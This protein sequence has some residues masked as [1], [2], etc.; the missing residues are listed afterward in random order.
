VS[1]SLER[2]DD[3]WDDLARQVDWYRDEAGPAVALRFVDAV[4]AT[5]RALLEQPGVGRLRFRDWPELRGVRSFRVRRPFHR[6][7][8]FYRNSDEGLLAE[9]LIYGGRDLPRRLRERRI[10]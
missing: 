8:I 1:L 9:R 6:F 5:L 10:S 4:E 7:L 3:F 2:S